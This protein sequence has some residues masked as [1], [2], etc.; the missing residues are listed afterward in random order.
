MAASSITNSGSGNNATST[1]NAH[2]KHSSSKDAF[3]TP[4]FVSPVPGAVASKDQLQRTLSGGMKKKKQKR[5]LDSELLLAANENRSS[6]INKS[7]ESS[8]LVK[9]K[10]K[11]SP[12]PSSSIGVGR[13]T[14]QQQLQQIKLKM[15][16][17]AAAREG[18]VPSSTAASPGAFSTPKRVAHHEKKAKK[19]LQDISNSSRSSIVPETPASASSADSQRKNSAST[20]TSSS[21][22]IPTRKLDFNPTPDKDASAAKKQKNRAEGAAASIGPVT[23]ASDSSSSSSDS[24]DS[25]SESGYSSDE[26]EVSF[27]AITLGN[28]RIIRE[29]ES[30]FSS[31]STASTSSLRP[32]GLEYRFSV[33]S[34]VSSIAV[35]PNGQ[36]LVVGFY[37]G[38]IYLYPL[39]KDSFRFRGGVLL[40]HITARGMYTQLMVRVA[41]P[42]DGKFIFAGVYRGSTEIRAFEVD[43]IKFPSTTASSAIAQV[44]SSKDSDDDD[45]DGDFGAPHA[46]AVTH[47]Y[48][49]AKLKGF[50]AVKSIIRS[51]TNSTEYHL[52]CGL[53]IKNVHL[54]RFFQQ[55]VTKEWSWECVF[56]KQANGISLEFLSFH[57]TIASQIISKSEHQN[58]RIWTLEEEF[59]DGSSLTITKKSH[60]DVKN[61]VDT[62]AV[63]GDYAYGGSEALAMINLRSAS[64]MELDLP[65]STKEQQAQ[66]EA[67]AASKKSSARITASMRQRNSRRR[68]APAGGEELGGGGGGGMRHMRTVSQVAGRET[69]P[70]TVGMC[71]DGSVFFHQP[72]EDGLGMATPLE[73]V[74]GYERFFTDPSLSFQAQFSDLTRVNTSGVLAVLPLPTTEKEDWMIVAANQDQL[75][76]RSLKAFLCRN[77]EIIEHAKVKRGLRN[78]MRDLGGAESSGSSS[79]SSSSSEGESESEQE[80]EAVTET[81]KSPSKSVKQPVE[82]VVTT[83]SSKTLASSSSSKA[84][85]VVKEGKERSK[86]TP[87]SEK[88]RAPVDKQRGVKKEKKPIV[89]AGEKAAAA[90]SSLSIKDWKKANSI[91]TQE[92]SAVKANASVATAPPLPLVVTT[93]KRSA[94]GAAGA[95]STPRMDVASPVVSISSLSSGTSNPNTPEQSKLSQREKQLLVLKDLEWTPPPKAP[96]SSKG[97]AAAGNKDKPSS[98]PRSTKSLFGNNDEKVKAPTSTSKKSSTTPGVAKSTKQPTPLAKKLENGVNADTKESIDLSSKA[99]CSNKKKALTGNNGD[100]VNEEQL[101]ASQNNN[102]SPEDSDVEMEDEEVEDEDDL[103]ALEESEPEF[104]TTP[105]VSDGGSLLAA[106]LFQFEMAASVSVVET[107]A[108]SGTV[109]DLTLNEQAN[110]LLHFA[111][112]N[113][114]LKRNFYVE[115]ERI[116]QAHDCP[117]S[118]SSSSR[119]SSVGPVGGSRANWKKSL[120]TDFLKRKQLKRRQK[121]QIALKLKQLHGKYRSQI[122]E[123]TAVHK[124]QA[125]ALTSRQRFNHFYQQLQAVSTSPASS[126][127]ELEASQVQPAE[128]AAPVTATAADE[129]QRVP[130]SFPY[131]TLL[132]SANPSSA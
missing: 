74:E 81:K 116:Y 46:Q 113:E 52:L 71:S 24:S 105:L 84:T 33:S 4:S 109:D 66:L 108:S 17:K 72:Q 77:Q 25:S 9:K 61:T 107:K 122:Q 20:S 5:K 132:S 69:S 18:D 93:P 30:P 87:V 56:D 51:K 100:Q 49:D 103:D 14:P 26:A 110:L 39:N 126:S 121:K 129:P 76:V 64:R 57:P 7:G 6:Y 54:W 47:T 19:P 32:V 127:K 117:C 131:P 123:L 37:N 106:S 13:L 58:I 62:T 80:F 12:S 97:S 21:T 99:A 23:A 22:H 65:L 115:K 63:F 73:Y 55:P 90:K 8:G 45:D 83:A 68:G 3:R 27:D 50:G 88:K 96:S 48:S 43:S 89:A 29:A 10:H 44:T 42:E 36:F 85:P 15:K 112:Q 79:S 118:S 70:F 104:I 41:L 98:K 86:S 67:A 130:I 78:V 92:S 16:L 38:T 31:A 60:V 53:G 28:T 40:D 34:T 1:P 82:E 95:S 125:D 35:A 114:R 128:P 2:T 94:T 11:L 120:S 102:K 111:D 101:K 59:Q 119:N 91:A 124:L 75:L